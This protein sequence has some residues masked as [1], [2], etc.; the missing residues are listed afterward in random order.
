MDRL[1]HIVYNLTESAINFQHAMSLFCALVHKTSQLKAKQRV[2]KE[3]SPSLT[4]H[5]YLLWVTMKFQN[6]LSRSH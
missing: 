4:K 6:S 1:S 3:L 2:E 5:S